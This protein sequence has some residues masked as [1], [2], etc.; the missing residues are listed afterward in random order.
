MKIAILYICTG[1]YN[2]FF[3]VFYASCEKYF[4]PESKKTYL[5]WTDDHHLSD[6]YPNVHVYHKECAG[7]PKDSLFRFEMFLQA[8]GEIRKNDFVYFFNSNAEIRRTIGNEIL[9]DESGL[10]MGIWPGVREHQHPMFY[11]YERNRKSLAY[12]KPYGRH[13]IYY[14]GGL[15]G[16]RVDEYLKMVH[17]LSANIRNDYDRGIIACYHDESHINAYLRHHPCKK[18]GKEYCCPEEWITSGFEP[19]NVFR[20]KTR[21][22]SYFNKGRK[23]DR[24]SKIKKGFGILWNAVRWYLYI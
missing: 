21:I 15:N 7:F 11:P 10:S 18:L 24:W 9:P 2:Q 17:A 20:E 6:D 12:V 16:G 22:D 19:Y 14:M 5:V 13:Y 1:R 4:I 23:F 3:K 8:E